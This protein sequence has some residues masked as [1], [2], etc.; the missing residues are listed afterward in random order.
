MIESDKQRAIDVCQDRSLGHP[1]P[2]HVDLLSK[3]Q[4]LCLQ[5]GSPLK[6]RGQQDQPDRV[7]H[8]VI[9]R[10]LILASTPNHIFGT[11]KRSDR[12]G[13]RQSGLFLV[14]SFNQAGH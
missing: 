2:K 5:L 10:N 8:R 4:I 1:E 11:H 9:L 3:D 6:E 7:G 12:N 14:R 13:E